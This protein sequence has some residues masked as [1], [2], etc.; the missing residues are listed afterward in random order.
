MGLLVSFKAC[1]CSA[2]GDIIIIIIIVTQLP[3]FLNVARGLSWP[4]YDVASA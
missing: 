1:V 2:T 4:K 3:R